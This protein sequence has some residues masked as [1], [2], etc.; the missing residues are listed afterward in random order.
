MTKPR[1]AI[2]CRVSTNKQE[3]DGTSLETQLARCREHAANMGWE[4]V[5]EYQEQISGYTMLS[6]RP[7]LSEALTLAKQG[8]LDILLVYK[9]DRFARNQVRSAEM[10]KAF[11]TAGAEVVSATEPIGKGAMGH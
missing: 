8:G 9:V 1:V 2:Y 5:R 11:D 6:A 7:M 10:W 3:E 4:V